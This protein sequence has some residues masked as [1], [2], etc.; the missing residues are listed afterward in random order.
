MQ[1]LKQLRYNIKYFRAYANEKNLPL[2]DSLTA[3]QPVVLG[4]NSL[5]EKVSEQLKKSGILVVAIR[6]PTVPIN[7]ARLRI[8]INA[9]HNKGQLELLVDTL[10]AMLKAESLENINQELNDNRGTL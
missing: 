10:A 9:E 5:V 7:T 8:T 3:I 4:R 1:R 2:S 6:P